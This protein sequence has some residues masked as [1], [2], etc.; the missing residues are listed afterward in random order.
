MTVDWIAFLTVFIAALTGTVVVVTLYAV[1]VRLLVTAGRVPVA[2]PAE[3][4]DA[5]TVLSKS[6][7]KQA[8]KRAAK[9]AKKNPLTQGQKNLA[10]AGA[11]ACFGLCAVAVLAGIYLIVPFF[12]G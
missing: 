8:A 1:G 6:E 9:A 11:Y 7:I 10:R 4:T 3:F 2:L 12:H 5:I